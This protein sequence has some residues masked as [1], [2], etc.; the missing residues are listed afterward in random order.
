MA[1]VQAELCVTAASLERQLFDRALQYVWWRVL[2]PAV[3]SSDAH[4][5]KPKPSGS[6]SLQH[7]DAHNKGSAASDEATARWL[8]ALEAMRSRLCPPVLTQVRRRTLHTSNAK[9]VSSCEIEASTLY[10]A[11]NT[12]YRA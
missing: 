7:M 4:A 6:K 2:V 3:A 1:C 10:R 9:Y 8:D 5:R 12:E 11:E